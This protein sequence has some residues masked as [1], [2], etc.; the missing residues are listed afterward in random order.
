M[1]R[2]LQAVGLFFLVG[3]LF[4]FGL[5]W[6]DG[7]GILAAVAD[8][9]APPPPIIKGAAFAIAPIVTPSPT[10]T[11]APTPTPHEAHQLPFYPSFAPTED[12]Q[13]A[14]P[15]PTPTPTAAP[16][17]EAQ[18]SAPAP[19]SRVRHHLFGD[20]PIIF[21][22]TG[23]VA[24][25]ANR[26]QSS[27]TSAQQSNQA[28]LSMQLQVSRRTERTSIVVQQ[29]FGLS[30]TSSN[31]SQIQ[32]G[33]NTPQYMLNFGPVSGPNDTQL[34]SG[35][36]NRGITVGVPRGSEETDVILARSVGINSEGYAIGGLR[37]TKMYQSGIAISQTL[38]LARGDRSGGRD[39]VFDLAFNRYRAGKTLHGE[40]AYAQTQGLTGV[41]DGAR[42]AWAL[43]A[44]FAGLKSSQSFGYTSIPNGYV[45]LGQIQFAQQTAQATLRRNVGRSGSMTLDLG[46]QESSIGAGQ[47]SHTVRQTLNLNV[48]V[49][50][51]L[52]VQAI[53]GTSV[54]SGGG[55]TSIQRQGGLS[56]GELIHGFSLGE[57][58]QG[59]TV[60]GS[61]GTS[62]QVQYSGSLAHMLFGGYATVQTLIGRMLT[63]GSFTRQ[64]ENLVSFSRPIGR[65]ADVSISAQSLNTLTHLDA[66]DLF[67]SSDAV[68]TSTT[69]QV[70]LLRR[71]SPVVA[72]RV[73]AG[74]THQSGQLGGSSSFVNVQIVGPL[75]IGSA[76]RY[77]GRIDPNLPA[78]IQGHVFYSDLSA[79]YGLA[80]NRGLANVLVIL[81][82]GLSERT[83]GTG[84]FEFRFVKPG[85][86]AVGLASGTLP[87]G[88]IADQG[89]QLVT[90]QGG[91]IANIDFAAGMFAGVGGHVTMG[92]SG[93]PVKGVGVSVDGL[94]QSFSGA[95]GTYQ[96][97]H[98]TPG[99][100][101]VALMVD[102][103][104]A[105]LAPAG[106]ARQTI[107]VPQT[108]I[109]TVNW[110]LAGL[111]GIEGT[112]LFTA[113]SGF[114]D[115]AG[116]KDVYV[117]ADPGQ[118]A[119]IT[120]PD[121]HFLIDNLP[122][123]EYTL[124]VDQD[125]LPDGQAIIQSPDGPVTVPSGETVQGITF[126]VG[127]A[128]KQVV[129]TFSGAKTAVVNADF[130]PDRVPPGAL[131][132]LVVTTDQKHPKSVIAQ[133]DFFG[134][135]V[136]H[137][138]A[139]RKAWVGQLGVSP[140]LAS[141][142]YAVH[143]TVKGDRDGSADTTLTV[144]NSL[145]LIYARGLPANAKAGQ[146]VR[147]VARVLADVRGG[148][149][150][151]FEDGQSIVLPA[152]RAHIVSF[153]VRVPHALP[154]RALLFTRK[155]E[156]LPFL[157]AP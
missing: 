96:I 133:G 4:G 79:G 95:D 34:S 85:Q 63:A 30:S 117:V 58:V 149:R 16:A 56:L 45:S 81:D 27:G 147:V 104:P 87:V 106:E 38:Y 65:K 144:N 132:D 88:M 82:G 97:G 118:H 31:L 90:V 57:T 123:G 54:V 6:A 120:G 130:K 67:A 107:D 3:G 25:G 146:E 145:P 64:T 40:V 105:A 139:G 74:R 11:P 125:T 66:T 102:S 100:H 140:T 156:R 68:T 29:A 52:N 22:G 21:S 44:T 119:A 53:E 15:T 55:Q 101:T 61:T 17:Q 110:T 129:F 10:A 99:K 60:A 69:A 70:S 8:P 33:Y 137:F 108:G 49:S 148:E 48:P 142:D 73:N 5:L 155:G 154:Y 2:L 143:V 80:G 13:G 127:P 39:T 37:H 111:G 157:V 153:S 114:G 32:I 138:D 7:A 150:L 98:L 26:I 41:P 89:S 19:C 92:A 35:A 136:L 84:A 50:Q 59:T 43:Q 36:F 103:L 9:C 14:P 83:D 28:Q 86:H 93:V 75:S 46:S 151:V 116:A 47:T 122:A 23:A 72:F 141:G 76:A 126:K 51:S 134:T 115:L 24:A 78:V 1:G 18:P 20:G 109:A 62:S 135:M 94:Q 128:A 77:G 42:V 112:V 91:Q 12:L 152:P 71:I 124:S 131:V 121:G 113:D